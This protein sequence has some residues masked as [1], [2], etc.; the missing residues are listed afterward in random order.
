MFSWTETRQCQCG[1]GEDSLSKSRNRAEAFFQS[2]KIAGIKSRNN[3]IIGPTEPG[4]S[5]K[6]QNI[7]SKEDRRHP[8]S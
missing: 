4:P 6:S 5:H 2:Q 1:A 7:F 8:G 3:Q